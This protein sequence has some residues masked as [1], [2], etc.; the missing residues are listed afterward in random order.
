MGMAAREASK[1]F[2]I[3]RTVAETVDLYE[4]LLATRPDLR[5][6]RE[7]G[8]RSRRTEK[9]S[10]MLNRSARSVGR[11]EQPDMGGAR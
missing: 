6:K 7:H 1:R 5:R 11:P 10:A 4:A 8:R 9:W 3:R 2:D